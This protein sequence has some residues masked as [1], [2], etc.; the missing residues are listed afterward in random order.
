MTVDPF[1]RWKH[2]AAVVVGSLLLAGL[3]L[4]AGYGPSRTIAAVPWFLLFAVMLIGPA[5]KLKPSIRDWYPGNFPLNWRSELGI[6]F[7]VWAIAHI[8]YVFQ[9][10]GW[11]LV[12]FVTGM[13]P[14]AAAATVGTIIAVIL[15][16]TSNNTAYQFFGPKAWKWHQSHGTYVMFWL[17]S[18]HVYDQTFVRGA[19]FQDPLHFAYV[20]TIVIVVGLHIAAFLKVVSHYREHGKYPGGV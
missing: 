5:T 10:F 1:N 16:I 14:W 17:L 20:A 11:T 6:W 12:G 15:A 3:L 2:H 13:S 19:P 8:V 9:A 18:V 7:V 4:L